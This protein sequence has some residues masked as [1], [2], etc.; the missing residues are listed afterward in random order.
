VFII[1]NIVLCAGVF[2]VTIQ[3]LLMTLLVN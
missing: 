2:H 3:A 1:L